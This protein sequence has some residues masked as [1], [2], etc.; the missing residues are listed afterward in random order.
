MSLRVQGRKFLVTGGAGL[1]G[2]NLTHRLVRE[3]AEVTASYYQREPDLLKERYR[4]ADFT[5]F[6]QCIALTKGMTD[7]FLCAI[8]GYSVEG[9]KA[10][11]VAGILPNIQMNASLLE[12]CRLN[13]VKKVIFVSSST[14]YPEADHP[15]RED[16]LDLNQ[17]PYELYLAV[18][19][20]YRYL[21][22]LCYFYHKRYGLQVGVIRA[23]N[24]YGP[25]DHFE[26]GKAHVLP[27]LV[28]RALQKEVPFKVWGTPNTVRDFIFVEDFVDA[29]LWVLDNYCVCDAVNVADGKGTT[30][31]EAVKLILELS[32]HS[33]DPEYD[34]TRPTAIPY[35]VLDTRKFTRLH[36]KWQRNSLREGLRQ[37][38]DWY[39]GKLLP[40]ELTR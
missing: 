2:T 26:E 39:Q 1:V 23:S 25:H 20:M 35:R 22:Q 9:T 29:I 12:A 32:G 37:T 30:I 13:G 10:K 11:P 38:I 16:E 15:V 18:G 33:V 21:E 31:G 27:A 24:I 3:G 40:K 5:N 19:W 6:E 14:V 8:Q 7:V 17:E 4:Q 28:K 36:S 34:T